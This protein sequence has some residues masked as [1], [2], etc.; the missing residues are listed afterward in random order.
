MR[1]PGVRSVIGEREHGAAREP[2]Q[3]VRQ[4]L[5]M[6]SILQGVLKIV[7]TEKGAGILLTALGRRGYAGEGRI[8]VWPAMMDGRQMR[9][10][11]QEVCCDV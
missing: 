3:A 5:A 1:M 8:S 2:C 10:Y 6:T 7:P 4:T 9:V 11:P